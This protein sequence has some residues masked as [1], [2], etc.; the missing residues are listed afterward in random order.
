MNQLMTTTMTILVSESDSIANHASVDKEEEEPESQDSIMNNDVM[1]ND[2]AGKGQ[3]DDVA[4][5]TYMDK[6]LTAREKVKNLTG[7]TVE[8]KRTMIPS[9]GESLRIMF[10]T[11]LND[12]PLKLA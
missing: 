5:M 4:S 10:V 12:L 2:S 11:L 9:F 6:L 3:D 8:R 1:S 7:D